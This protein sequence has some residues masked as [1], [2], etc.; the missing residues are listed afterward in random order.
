MATKIFITHGDSTSGKLT[1][2]PS[3]T[4]GV[5]KGKRVIWKI[6][7]DNT[8]VKSFFIKEKDSP[9]SKD[10]FYGID[11]PP[12]RHTREGGARVKHDAIDYSEYI[13]TIH[14]IDEAGKDQEHDPI[15]SVK[16][17]PFDGHFLPTPLPKVIIGIAVGLA[18]VLSL[19]FLLK[20]RKKNNK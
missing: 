11:Q 7:G 13:Y 15:I 14:W 3:G 12:K 1:L 16:P 18:A 17:T 6:E 19:Q 20:K 4:V 10:I 8:N 5:E 9:H 2:N